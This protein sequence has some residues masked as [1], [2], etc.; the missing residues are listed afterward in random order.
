MDASRQRHDYCYGVAERSAVL[1]AAD[2]SSSRDSS[3]SWC[4]AVT[5]RR[6][7]LRL[8]VRSPPA[9]VS[10]RV[11]TANRLIVPQ[12]GSRLL[13]P[14]AAGDQRPHPLQPGTIAQAQMGPPALGSGDQ[15]VGQSGH[16]PAREPVDR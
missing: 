14:A 4:L 2:V 7:S 15:Q 11:R 8:G 1:V 16:S 5:A 12:R 6:L 3:R 10:S 9:T 13:C